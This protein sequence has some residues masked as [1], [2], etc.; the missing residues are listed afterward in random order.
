MIISPLC[1]TVTWR[2]TGVPRGGRVSDRVL[3]SGQRGLSRPAV[4]L[5]LFYS[6]SS[7]TTSQ[8]ARDLDGSRERDGLVFAAKLTYGRITA[9]QQQPTNNNKPSGLTR[10]Y[11]ATLLRCQ[12]K[13]IRRA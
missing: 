5:G 12:E 13:H 9:L 1:C 11:T 2:V 7:L 10:L 4:L 3:S 6:V 8:T